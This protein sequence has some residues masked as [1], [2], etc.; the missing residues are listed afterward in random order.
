MKGSLTTHVLDITQG[1]P[2]A[3]LAFE[4]WRV[5]RQGGKR[6]LLK[7]AHTNAEGRTDFPLLVEDELT[8]GCY[9]MVFMVGE[10]FSTQAI[11]TPI[12]PF[13]D[14]VP[15]RFSIAD[16]SAHYHVPLLTSPWSYS[17]YRGC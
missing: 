9:E 1:R 5:D 15:I 11:E 3:H 6:T 13:L 2:A 10:Y 7:M 8:V 16:P 4:L 17:M 14:Q 12:P